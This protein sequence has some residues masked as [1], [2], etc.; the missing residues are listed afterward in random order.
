MI[1]DLVVPFGCY[2]DEKALKSQ[3]SKEISRYYP[4][5]YAVMRIDRG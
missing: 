1:F 4:K 3:I 5:Y 2:P